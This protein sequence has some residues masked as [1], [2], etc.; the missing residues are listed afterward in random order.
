MNTPAT[1]ADVKKGNIVNQFPNRRQRRFSI[2][3][4]STKIAKCSMTEAAV[5]RTNKYG[6]Q[7]FK[8]K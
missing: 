4:S 1:Q 5:Y 7:R 8:K 2:V 3:P 6:T